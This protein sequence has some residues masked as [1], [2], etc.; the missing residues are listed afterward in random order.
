[1]RFTASIA[2]TI[3]AITMAI[4]APTPDGLLGGVVDAVA[5]V[6]GGV[7]TTVNNLLGFGEGEGER[8]NHGGDLGNLG[9]LGS[10][11]RN[12][13]NYGNGGYNNGNYGNGG[14]NNGGYNNGGYRAPEHEEHGGYQ[15]HGPEH[16]EHGGYQAH[17]PEHEEHGNGGY[18]AN[19]PGGYGN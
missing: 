15:A 1:M 8:G 6:T 17:G 12:N 11:N 5:P 13:G 10:Y 19:G 14:F 9:N 4:A 16:E 2:L 3:S 18:I 7:G